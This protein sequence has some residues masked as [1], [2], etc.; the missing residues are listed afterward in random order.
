[1]IDQAV[2]MYNYPRVII[3]LA[4]KESCQQDHIT[5]FTKV[6]KLMSL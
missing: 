2:Q 1:M 5:K 3:L 4:T 6:A